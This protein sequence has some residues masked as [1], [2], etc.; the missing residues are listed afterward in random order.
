VNGQLSRLI[1]KFCEKTKQPD[2]RPIQNNQMHA[3]RPDELVKQKIKKM[4]KND[5]IKFIKEMK[6]AIK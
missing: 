1:R 3:N 4:N 5:K 6:E 2:Y